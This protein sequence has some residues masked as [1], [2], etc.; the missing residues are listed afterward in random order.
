MKEEGIRDLI[1][2]IATFFGKEVEDDAM[3]CLIEMVKN[4]MAQDPELVPHMPTAM[5]IKPPCKPED[6][7]MVVKVGSEYRPASSADLV[8]VQM[9]LAQGQND[10]NLTIV[11][12]HAMEFELIPKSAFQDSKMVVLPG[13]D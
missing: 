11:T 13:Q 7:V 3:D 2:R 8:Q 6:C 1:T 10:P 5:K 12:H 9:S 4:C